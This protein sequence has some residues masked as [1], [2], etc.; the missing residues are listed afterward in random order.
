M[1]MMMMMMMIMMK[2]IKITG[3][4]CL[5]LPRIKFFP[6]NFKKNFVNET[7]TNTAGTRI[8]VLFTGTLLAV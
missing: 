1:M 4:S 6:S 7:W 5:R 2:M 8:R 3:N